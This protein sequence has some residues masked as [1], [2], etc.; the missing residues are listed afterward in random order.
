VAAGWPPGGLVA[1]TGNRPALNLNA[2]PD[3]S[4]GVYIAWEEDAD[5]SPRFNMDI[6]MQRVTGAGSIATGWEPGGNIVC[7]QAKSQNLPVLASDALA[8]A[9]GA[10]GAIVAWIDNRSTAT[11]MGQRISAGGQR[12]WEG[13]GD[14]NGIPICDG[15][16]AGT[17]AITS[18]GGGGAIIAWAGNGLWAQRVA[19]S[20][21]S[22]VWASSPAGK[23]LS[24]T[25]N[26]PVVAG[27]GSAG[28]IF[29]WE[30]NRRI[31]VQGVTAAGDTRWQAGN[32]TITQDGHEPTIARTGED[33]VIVAWG[34]PRITPT[35]TRDI[36]AQ[37]VSWSTQP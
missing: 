30:E 26:R 24:T 27:D 11:I 34:T 25:G 17:P 33:H 19:P 9:T 21:G 20:D 4:G 5:A 36:H 3:G 28:A 23:R 14:F 16:R 10:H 22:P 29:V 7:N 35:S 6:Y 15:C 31:L 32:L 1:R 18:D 37:W 12:Q 8:G 13:G 2:I